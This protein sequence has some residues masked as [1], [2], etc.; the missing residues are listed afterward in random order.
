MIQTRLCEISSEFF[1]GFQHRVDLQGI[2]SI[3]EIIALT[4]SK[5]R[6]V[7]ASHRFLDLVDKCDKAQWH[8]HTHTFE[9][10]FTRED[11]IYI[12]DHCSAGGKIEGMDNPAKMMV[13]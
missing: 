7:L 6:G 3:D 9:D 12:C 4:I 1:G 8:I 11:T 2:E 5:L 13:A 10:I